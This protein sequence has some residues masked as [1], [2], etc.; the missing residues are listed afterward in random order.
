[1]HT[2]D[3]ERA[4]RDAPAI[5]SWTSCGFSDRVHGDH[6]A[7]CALASFDDPLKRVEQ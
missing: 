5:A 7:A 6:A 3:G 2:T 1:M 4:T